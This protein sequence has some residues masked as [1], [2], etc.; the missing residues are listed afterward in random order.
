MAAKFQHLSTLHSK[1]YLGFVSKLVNE[2][3]NIVFEM[4]LG[5]WTW[6]RLQLDLFVRDVWLGASG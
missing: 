4:F 3:K 5:F 6:Q 1:R 2:K